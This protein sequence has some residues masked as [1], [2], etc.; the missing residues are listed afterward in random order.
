MMLKEKL[1]K[2]ID[3]T[4]SLQVTEAD[5]ISGFRKNEAF[6]YGDPSSWSVFALTRL[7]ENGSIEIKYRDGRSWRNLIDLSSEDIEGFDSLIWTAGH[8]PYRISSKNHRKVIARS[9]DLNVEYEPNPLR[10]A[11]NFHKDQHDEY[12]MFR[13]WCRAFVSWKE[14]NDRFWDRVEEKEARNEQKRQEWADFIG[15]YEELLK[16]LEADNE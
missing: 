11:C 14:H 15:K 10:C 8:I 5:I 4:N 16:K 3:L 13:G 7:G 9:G 12:D 2:A 1:L 6:G